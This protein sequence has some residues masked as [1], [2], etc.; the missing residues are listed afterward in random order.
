MALYLVSYDINHKNESEY[1]DLWATLERWGAVK[2]LYSEWVITG[3]PGSASAIYSEI[4]PTIRQNDRLIVQEIGRDCAWDRLLISDV[5]FRQI[6][7]QNAR[8]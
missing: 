3:S 8:L 6:V 7:T 5:Q 2:I 4:S 1:P